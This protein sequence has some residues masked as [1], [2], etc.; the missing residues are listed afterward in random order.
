MELKRVGLFLEN[1]DKSIGFCVSFL[2]LRVVLGDPVIWAC[3]DSMPLNG[4]ASR[5][6]LGNK[7][8]KSP[9][10]YLFLVIR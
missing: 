8:K 4:K 6:Y 5:D 9:S 7:M 2:G 3:K 1:R 10:A